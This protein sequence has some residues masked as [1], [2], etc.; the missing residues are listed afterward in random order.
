MWSERKCHL[1]VP[2]VLLA[3]RNIP[4]CIEPTLDKVRAWSVQQCATAG[5][6]RSNLWAPYDPTG[7][8]ASAHH[9]MLGVAFENGP[10]DE[11]LLLQFQYLLQREGDPCAGCLADPGSLSSSH[12]CKALGVI[13]RR[14][15]TYWPCLQ[16][17]GIT[18][19]VLCLVRHSRRHEAS[20]VRLSLKQSCKPGET[21]PWVRPR[22]PRYRAAV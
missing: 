7:P 18:H 3:V 8:A 6:F 5:C 19:D 22:L 14:S 10:P 1:K 16:E 12:S 4:A 9:S 11:V 2:P 20:S 13:T 21:L 17:S 15:D